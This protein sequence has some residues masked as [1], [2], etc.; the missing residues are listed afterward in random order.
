MISMNYL[1]MMNLDRKFHKKMQSMGLRHNTKVHYSMCRKSLSQ[2]RINIQLMIKL[3]HKL[4]SLS[5]E[6]LL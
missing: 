6:F 2:L 1:L 4:L 5:V 3:N